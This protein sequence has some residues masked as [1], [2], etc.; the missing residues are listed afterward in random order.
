MTLKMS[1]NLQIAIILDPND[2]LEN[3]YVI[4]RAVKSSG[5]S[6]K[7]ISERLS[8]DYGVTLTESGV[9]HY[10]NRGSMKLQRTLQIL[11]ICGVSSIEI[12]RMKVES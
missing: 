8:G 3:R 9:S 4:H 2:E 1:E 6:L 7:E 12:K 10:V 5:L 11:S